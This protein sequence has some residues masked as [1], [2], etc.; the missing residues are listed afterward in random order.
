MEHEQRALVAPG[1]PQAL[2]KVG[3]VYPP[4]HLMVGGL[5]VA[6]TKQ[7]T[8]GERRRQEDT[9]ETLL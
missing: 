4:L 8:W 1:Y 6:K 9:G 2:R 5:M 7:E 3:D